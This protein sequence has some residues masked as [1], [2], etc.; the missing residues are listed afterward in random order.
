MT[1]SFSFI[2]L[3]IAI[4]MD[5][6]MA[7]VAINAIIIDTAVAM[8]TA[9]K[10]VQNDSEI[11]HMSDIFSPRA[12][13]TYKLTITN[14]EPWGSVVQRISALNTLNNQ[15]CTLNNQACT[16]IINEWLECDLRMHK[17]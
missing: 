10:P 9:D 6:N 2:N 5:T 11:I 13:K 8:D 15:A 1:T 12:F 16:L 7:D 14:E 3:Q 4:R 17:N